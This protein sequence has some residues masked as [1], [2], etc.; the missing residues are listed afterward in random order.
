MKKGILLLFVILFGIGINISVAGNGIKHIVLIGADGFGSFILNKHKGS[1][2]HIEKMIKEGSSALD[3]R[4]VLPSSSAVNWASM[5]MGAGPELHG[6]TEWGSK[7]PELPSRV[8]GDY[9]LFPG[10]F[11]QM[12]HAY[13]EAETGVVY[14]WEGIGFLYEKDAV[15]FNRFEKDDDKLVLQTAVTYLKEKKPMLSFIYFSQPDGAG[16]S[17]GW[18]SPEYF[19]ECKKIDSYVGEIISALKDAGIYEDCVVIFS[20][21]HGGVEKGHGGKTMQEMQI[22]YIVTGK[23]IKSGYNISESTM[24]YDNAATIAYILGFERPQVWVSR[25]IMSIFK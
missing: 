16:H 24:I 4:S 22:P 13:P 18:D 9:G 5:L 23:N 19:E 10:I 6:Y 1:F 3:M 11:G 21:D 20:S 12:R 2:P 7:T 17:I 14:S 15:T 25:P 8:T